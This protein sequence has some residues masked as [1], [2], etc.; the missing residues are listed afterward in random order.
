MC[1]LCVATDA[2]GDGVATGVGFV[3]GVPATGDGST[4]VTW[5]ELFASACAM[6]GGLDDLVFECTRALLKDGALKGFPDAGMIAL[7]SDY[8]AEEDV[9]EFANARP[10]AE[11]RSAD[12]VQ[13]DVG[14][15]V[16]R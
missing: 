12:S 2:L 11:A 7:A 3:V 8:K 4:V 9:L 6:L 1:V 16:K 15:E 5:E 14:Q 13:A 10:H